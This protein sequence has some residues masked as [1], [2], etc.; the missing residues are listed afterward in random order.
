MTGGKQRK[1]FLNDLKKQSFVFKLMRDCS[2]SKVTPAV[3]KIIAFLK[4]NSI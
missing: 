3:S 1:Q 2:S 4:K